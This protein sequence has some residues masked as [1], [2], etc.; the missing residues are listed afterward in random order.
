MVAEQTELL[1]QIFSLEDDLSRHTFI[2]DVVLIPLVR[3]ME[4]LSH[5]K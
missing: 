5:D 2:E 3:H 4:I 1:F